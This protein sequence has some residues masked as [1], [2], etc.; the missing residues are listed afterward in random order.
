[1]AAA[2][3][4]AKLVDAEVLEQDFEP[5]SD[6]KDIAAVETSFVEVPEAAEASVDKMTPDSGNSA[7]EG[8]VNEFDPMQVYVTNCDNN[9]TS[10]RAGGAYL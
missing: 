8:Q 9:Q 4:E 5:V 3:N 1:M 2:K 10:G 6:S 7:E